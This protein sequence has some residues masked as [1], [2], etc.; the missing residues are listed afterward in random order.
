[1]IVQDIKDR[2]K[3]LCNRAEQGEAGL[4]DEGKQ[5]YE[6]VLKAIATGELTLPRQAALAR[7]GPRSISGSS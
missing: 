6:D 2:V 5:L 4:E 3:A 1:M 7:C